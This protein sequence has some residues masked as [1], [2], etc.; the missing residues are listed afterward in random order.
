MIFLYVEGMGDYL[1][2]VTHDKRIMSLLNF[3][4][5]ED[6]LPSDKFCRVHKSYVVAFDKIESIER[7]RIKISDKII[8]I[9]E[10]YKKTFF[11]FLEKK[12]LV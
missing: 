2:L 10:T 8:P 11:D 9:S 5:L 6:M 4:K 7:N 1:R 12:K 3:K